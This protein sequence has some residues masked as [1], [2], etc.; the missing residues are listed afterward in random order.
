M[1]P[2]EGKLDKLKDM[3]LAILTIWPGLLWPGLGC[4]R[5]GWMCWAGLWGV[6]CG[7]GSERWLGLA[8]LAVGWAGLGW[9]D[10]GWARRAEHVFLKN[11]QALEI[12]RTILLAV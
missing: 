8:V 11:D 4:A 10:L 6:T 7:P 2:S 1:S 3:C 5:L 12:S 9:A